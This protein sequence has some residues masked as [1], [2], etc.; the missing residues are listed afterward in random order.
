[1]PALLIV[2]FCIK[3]SDLRH[4]L[5][6]FPFNQKK[7]PL[8]RTSQHHI[9][10]QRPNLRYFYGRQQRLTRN[11]RYSGSL[12]LGCTQNKGTAPKSRQRSRST[13]DFECSN[14]PK[15]CPREWRLIN[16]HIMH[17]DLV[18]LGNGVCGIFQK[19]FHQSM[20]LR[21]IVITGDT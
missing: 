14:I 20:T 2:I 15:D 13:F 12:I 1:M 21:D 17:S 19:Q 6:T 16:K 3:S 18:Q 7:I 8:P 11:S 5:K 10:M 9:N 4:F